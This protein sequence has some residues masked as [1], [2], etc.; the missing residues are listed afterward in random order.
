MHLYRISHLK[1][2][3]TIVKNEAPYDNRPPG[4]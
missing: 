4:R 2:N 1:F 3:Q